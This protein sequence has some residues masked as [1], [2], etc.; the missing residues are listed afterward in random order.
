M[1]TKKPEIKHILNTWA[2][3]GYGATGVLLYAHALEH[4]QVTPVTALLWITEVIAPATVGVPLLGDTVR[5]GW[6]PAAAA[7]MAAAVGAAAVL[8]G[9]PAQRQT[10]TPVPAGN[11]RQGPAPGSTRQ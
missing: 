8:A 10:A 3:V 11:D 5:T 9:S 2:L 4:G 7:A 1:K 6:L